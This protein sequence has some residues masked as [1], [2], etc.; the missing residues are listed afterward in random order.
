M[1][2]AT[3]CLTGPEGPLLG[4]ERPTDVD[5][6]GVISLKAVPGRVLDPWTCC[7]STNDHAAEETTPSGESERSWDLCGPRLPVQFFGKCML[8]ADT[9]LEVVPQ[10]LLHFPHEIQAEF[11]LRIEAE[12][13]LNCLTSLSFVSVLQV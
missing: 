12:T 8:L 3:T 13:Y 11:I 6:I 1:T 9:L 5:T 2:P 7:T 10:G 4:V